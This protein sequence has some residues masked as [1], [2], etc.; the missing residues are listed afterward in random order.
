MFFINDLNVVNYLNPF[1][2]SRTIIKTK[3]MDSDN[4]ITRVRRHYFYF[5]YDS[6]ECISTKENNIPFSKESSFHIRWA[7]LR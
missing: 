4:K 6:S 7:D 2:S 1:S 5:K 3:L